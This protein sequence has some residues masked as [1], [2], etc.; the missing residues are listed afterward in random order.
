MT[1][2]ID[3]LKVDLYRAFTTKGFWIGL[4]ST[5]VVFIFSSVGMV[6]PQT[7]AVVVFNNTYKYNNISQMLFLVSTFAYSVSFCVDCETKYIY[8]ITIR[9]NISTYLAVR[10]ISVAIMGGL[11]VTLGALAFISGICICQPS[12]VPSDIVIDV[13]LS[14]Q[15]FGDLLVEK[16]VIMYF[17]SYIVVIFLQSGFFSVLGLTV[18]SYLPNPYIAYISPFILAF[19][20]NQIA[21]VCRF[22]IWLDPVKLATAN[23]MN[24]TWFS[25]LVMVICVYG[26]F[27]IVCS[28]LFI[29]KVRRTIYA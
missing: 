27:I 22:P 24:M 2:I 7:S 12:I 5:V 10:C 14:A 6:T 15:A 26:T 18:S 28:Y 9:S 25:I 4:F 19:L 17:A 11:S 8:E 20:L 1:R 13:E 23:V 29:R 3:L 16:R 21:N